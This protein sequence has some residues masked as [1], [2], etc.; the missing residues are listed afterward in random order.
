MVYMNGKPKNALTINETNQVHLSCFVDGNPTPEVTLRKLTG[1]RPLVQIVNH[2]LNYTLNM[3]QCSDT[4]T[5]ECVGK[6]TEF[7]IRIQSFSVN[8]LCEPR[9]DEFTLV[10]NIYGSKSG[11][12][13]KVVVSLPVVANPL[14]S[15]LGFVWL[16]PTFESISIKVSQRNDVFYKH[17][18]NST[19]PVPDRRSFGTYS[20]KYKGKVFADITIHAE[21]V[22]TDSREASARTTWIIVGV[23]IGLSVLLL[24]NFGV[25]KFASHRGIKTDSIQPPQP[26]HD[27]K[28]TNKEYDDVDDVTVEAHDQNPSSPTYEDVTENTEQIQSPTDYQNISGHQDNQY[29]ELK[30]DQN[31]LY[32]SLKLH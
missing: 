8:V 32:S 11:P 15:T 6:S 14:T 2:W 10:K 7:G 28:I 19:I 5:F 18:I 27:L 3:A 13:V 16:G 26:S 1:N 30:P 4:G 20:L 23:L 24:T 31:R 17:W 29:Q 9:L 25:Y 12:D 21:G 22:S